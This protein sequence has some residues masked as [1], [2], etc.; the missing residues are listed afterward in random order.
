MSEITLDKIKILKRKQFVSKIVLNWC[1]R[2]GLNV[3]KPIEHVPSEILSLL[4]VKLYSFFKPK[5]VE[6]YVDSLL[7]HKL[8]N[9]R[10]YKDL[11]FLKGLPVR[12]QRTHTNARIAK[13]NANKK[14]G[15]R[16][17]SKY[18]SEN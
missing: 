12:G 7:V 16:D 10:N 11:R 5:M 1:K 17:F 6:E 4:S 13:Y 9:R 3:R 2:C 15:G 18:Q 14:I 8:T